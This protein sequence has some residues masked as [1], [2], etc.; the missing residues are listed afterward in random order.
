M[1]APTN[2]YVDPLNGN[3]ST[4]DGTSGTPW[5]SVQK[6]LNTITRNATNGDQI[7]VK[8]GAADVLAASLSLS[9]YGTATET[10]P[11]IL[12]GYTTTANDGGYGAISGGNSVN[13]ADFYNAS[14][15]RVYFVDMDLGYGAASGKLLQLY[16][17]TLL[18]CKVHHAATGVSIVSGHSVV[19]H[20]YIYSCTSYSIET[21]VSVPVLIYH[22]FLKNRGLYLES[23]LGTVAHNI[24][25][26]DTNAYGIYCYGGGDALIQNSIYANGGNGPGIHTSGATYQRNVILNNVVEG[27]SGGIGIN[28]PSGVNLLLYGNNKVYNCGTAFSMSG[29]PVLDVGNNSTLAASPFTDAANGDF[30]VSTALKAAGYPSSFLGS[31]TNQYLDIG[32]AQRQEQGAGGLAINPIGSHIIRGLV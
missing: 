22:N 9:T 32:A 8:A 11:L 29:D 25:S 28:V 26:V 19:A 16:F 12:R 4:G 3:D 20:C 13:I 1:A 24:I 30:S 14:K 31:N 6:A 5:K 7:N 18:R 15:P 10:A 21:Y 27:F 17:G 2:Y 23:S